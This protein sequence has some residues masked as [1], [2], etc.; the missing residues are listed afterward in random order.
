ME[1][2]GEYES[3]SSDDDREQKKELVTAA[4]S[5]EVNEG[6]DSDSGDSSSEGPQE[7]SSSARL[8]EEKKEHEPAVV[9][10][11]R[12]SAFGTFLL[13]VLD[14]RCFMRNYLKHDLGITTTE[15][16]RSFAVV[17]PWGTGHSGGIVQSWFVNM[18]NGT[19][20]AASARG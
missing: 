2:F 3:S 11:F 1:A 19:W 10:V 16:E 9:Q 5:K 12:P 8:G 14:R 7:N 17:E 4:P 15:K 6:S 13:R 18:G 20:A